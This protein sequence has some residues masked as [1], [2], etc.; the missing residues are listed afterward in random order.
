MLWDLLVIFFILAFAYAFAFREDVPN[1]VL[2]QSLALMILILVA[3]NITSI[4]D[5]L[6]VALSRN[7]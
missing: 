3:L 7:I 5:Y 2:I 4:I 6:T 1:S